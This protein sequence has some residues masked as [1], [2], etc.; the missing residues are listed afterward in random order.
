M[1]FNGSEESADLGSPFELYLFRYGEQMPDELSFDF[2]SLPIAPGAPDAK[3]TYTRVSPNGK[4]VAAVYDAEPYIRVYRILNDD[5]YSISV[6]LPPGGFRATATSVDFSH[7][8]VHMIIGCKHETREEIVEGEPVQVQIPN[9]YNYG[10]TYDGSG[11][12][13]SMTSIGGIGSVDRPVAGDEGQV[14]A[15][16]YSPDGQHLLVGHDGF[17]Y[18]TFYQRSGNVYSK[19]DALSENAPGPALTIDFGDTTTCVVTSLEDAPI[20]YNRVGLAYNRG[21]TIPMLLDDGEEITFARFNPGGDR[22]AVGRSMPPYL[23]FYTRDGNTLA[24]MIDVIGGGPT[25]APADA[26]FDELSEGLVVTMPTSPYAMTFDVK[27]TVVVRKDEWNLALTGAAGPVHGVDNIHLFIGVATSPYLYFIKREVLVDDGAAGYY[28]YTNNEREITTTIDGFG[29][30]TFEPIA[31]N[32]DAFKANGKADP[33]NMKISMPSNT[34]LS[35]LFLPFPPPQ[36]VGVTIFQGH[37]DDLDAELTL[38]WTGKILSVSHER[39]EV[40]LNCDNNIV[41]MSRLGLRRNYQF[42]CPYVLYGPLCK[43]SKENASVEAIV[44]SVDG[45]DLVLTAGWYGGRNPADFAGGYLS[46][47]SKIGTEYRTINNVTVGGAIS[48]VGPLRNIEPGTEVTITLGCNHQR[49]HC[50]NLHN[51]INNFG[52]QPWIP[53]KNPVKYHPFW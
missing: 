52:G 50:A 6:P 47:R 8:S 13:V 29:T 39:E 36:P 22:I 11:Q 14:H 33:N 23:N 5:L 4:L 43:A 31:I 51:N 3:V 17:P 15:V 12:P 7:D 18:L 38:V 41:S 24:P 44:V 30:V 25:S 40:V 2:Q 21:A 42:G 28:A 10:I 27:D 35:V 46:W 1:S 48:Y 16:C 9:M 20:M 53:L 37:H 34:D 49:S 19:F 26:Y 32:R 45:G